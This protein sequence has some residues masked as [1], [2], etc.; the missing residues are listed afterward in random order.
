MIVV[1]P[2][3]QESKLDPMTS[4]KARCVTAMLIVC[5][6]AGSAFAGTTM[7]MDSRKSLT[8]QQVRPHRVCLVWT[9][10][11]GIPVPCD[12]VFTAVP[13]TALPLQIIGCNR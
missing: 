10:T 13:T 6:F 8:H 12:R 11:S 1:V 3:Q 5:T 2:R 7:K 4:L 9:S